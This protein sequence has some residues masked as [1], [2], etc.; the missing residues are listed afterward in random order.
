MLK[1]KRIYETPHPE[2]GARYLVDALWPRGVSREDADLSGWL[3]ELVPSSRLRKWFDHDPRHWGKFRQ[4]YRAE[5]GAALKEEILGR[6]AAQA[7]EENVTLLFAARDQKHNNA[8]ALK[9]FIQN[10]VNAASEETTSAKGGRRKNEQNRRFLSKCGLE[11]R[12]TR[13]G[14][15]MPGQCQGG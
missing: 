15:R 4:R 12:E 14:D 5:L 13:T 9:D 11:I 6:L 7:S 8:E 2:D 1:T 10:R 3:K